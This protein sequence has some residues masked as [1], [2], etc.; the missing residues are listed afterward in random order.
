MASSSCVGYCSD[1][2]MYTTLGIISETAILKDCYSVSSGQAIGHMHAIFSEAVLPPPT[3]C[4][5]T[6]LLSM[7]VPLLQHVTAHRS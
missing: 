4:L 1:L 5:D 7:C 2:T 3:P 6:P